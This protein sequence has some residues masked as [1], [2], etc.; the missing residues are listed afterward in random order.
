MYDAR[1]FH[2]QPLTAAPS[3]RKLLGAIEESLLLNDPCMS[4]KGCEVKKIRPLEDGRLEIEYRLKLVKLDTADRVTAKILGRVYDDDNGE[5]EYQRLLERLKG[6][7]SPAADPFLKGFALYIPEF[8]LLLCS[9]AAIYELD[10]LRVALDSEAIKPHLNYCLKTGTHAGASISKCEID[11]LRY[12]PGRR[13]TLRYRLWARDPHACGSQERTIIGKIYKNEAKSR[14]IL[15]VISELYHKG[16]GGDSMDG[17]RI[18]GPLGHIPELAM[19]LMEYVPGPS[20]RESFSSPR[21]ADHLAAAA[22]ALVKIHSCSLKGVRKH[23]VSDEFA[24]LNRW[25]VKATWINP[26]LAPALETSLRDIIASAHDLDCPETVLTHGDF[27]PN[28]VLLGGGEVTIVDFDSVCNADPARDIG[29]FLAHLRLRVIERSWAE[30]KMRIYGKAFL[31][32]YRPGI[33]SNLRARIDFY[34]R[35]FLLLFACQASCVP[36]RRRMATSFLAEAGNGY[37]F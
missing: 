14:R 33:P 7:G 9:P 2:H 6:N 11:V 12:K 30:D 28:H 26:D 32:A 24:I 27:S 1:T 21:L 29:H 13:C 36:K 10:G 16:F 5:R 22:R 4:V 20:L 8:R 31:A 15:R 34:Y 25:V 19:V 3:P 37:P 17:I 23:Q 35:T 18:P